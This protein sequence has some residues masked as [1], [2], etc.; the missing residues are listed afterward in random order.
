MPFNVTNNPVSGG[1]DVVV[2]I[3]LTTQGNGPA[4]TDIHVISVRWNGIDLQ[5]EGYDGAEGLITVVIPDEAEPGS[6]DFDIDF[7]TNEDGDDT[8]GG[9]SGTDTD[10]GNATGGGYELLPL[11]QI[12]NFSPTAV[13]PNQ[14]V[15]VFGTRL[16]DVCNWR[17]GQ[18]AIH[19]VRASNDQANFIIPSQCVAGN[20]FVYGESRTYLMST[21]GSDTALRVIL[22]TG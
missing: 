7:E 2:T 5:I 13:T 11:P 16:L 4:T 22:P 19:N 6:S 1:T 3:T 14:S 15:T 17:V 21:I 20:Y 8:D 18:Y 9:E 10:E 12:I